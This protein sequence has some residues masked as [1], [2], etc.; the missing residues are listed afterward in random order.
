E[1]TTIT[2][3]LI[4]VGILIHLPLMYAQM[5]MVKD[6]N[7]K[8]TKD[9]IIAPGED[10]RD[11]SNM[12]FSLGFAWA[13]I[14]VYFPMLI[15]STIGVLME[16]TWGYVLFCATGLLAVYFSIVFWVAERKYV[17]PKNG[18]IMYYTFFWGFFF[19]WGLVVF[20]FTL[21]KIE[22]VKF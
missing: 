15:L 13:D 5:L 21:L 2:W 17:L 8:K 4:I 3:V 7:A 9:I 6:P 14:L 20:I 10:W 12:E 22:D 16:S 19:Y 18:P 11:T 1:L